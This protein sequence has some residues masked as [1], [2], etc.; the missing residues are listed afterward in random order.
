[1]HLLQGSC[2]G[3][4]SHSSEGRSRLSKHGQ[5]RYWSYMLSPGD[6]STMKLLTIRDTV[7]P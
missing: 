7:L 3:L 2:L 5:Y 1:M 6:E 4:H